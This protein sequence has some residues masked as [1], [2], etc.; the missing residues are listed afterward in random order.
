MQDSC[1]SSNHKHVEMGFT[2]LI[3][4]GSKGILDAGALVVCT[5]F[6]GKIYK[7]DKYI[8]TIMCHRG[9]EPQFDFIRNVHTT[10]YEYEPIENLTVEPVALQTAPNTDRTRYKGTAYK[11]LPHGQHPKT[12]HEIILNLNSLFKINPK[13]LYKIKE[14]GP[15]RNAD[16]NI[17]MAQ[18]DELGNVYV[19]KRIGMFERCT[20]I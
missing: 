3:K 6:V 12:D 15:G 8:G 2:E 1:I 17:C 10:L 11:H 5:A 16:I 18:V 7:D 9:L 19:P 4:E 14:Y 13:S 20:I